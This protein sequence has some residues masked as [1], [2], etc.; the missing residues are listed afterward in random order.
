M[1]QEIFWGNEKSTEG[2]GIALDLSGNMYQIGTM[3]N[4]PH[5]N[6]DI[7]LVKF[8]ST[9]MEQWNITLGTDNF[10]F[11]SDVA[12]D[13]QGNVY[14][15]GTWNFSAGSNLHH[16]GLSKIYPNG[17][18]AWTILAEEGTLGNAI[19]L[20]DSNT[21][22]MGGWSSTL[23]DIII[24]KYDITGEIIWERAWH[25]NDQDLI[26]SS[27]LEVDSK[28]NVYVGATTKSLGA[29]NYDALLIKYNNQGQ[30][31]WNRTWG[32]MADDILYSLTIDKDDDIIIGG[33]TESFQVNGRDSIF[34][35]SFNETGELNKE[36]TWSSEQGA[37]LRNI[38]Q[39]AEEHLI[40]TGYVRYSIS[41]KSVLIGEV[42]NSLEIMRWNTTWGASNVISGNA[43][44][45]DFSGNL[46]ILGKFDFLG[47][48][49]NDAFILKYSPDVVTSEQYYLAI[50]QIIQDSLKYNINYY[51]QQEQE[52]GQGYYPTIHPP[53]LHATY[54]ALYILQS[55]G[56]LDEIN[57]QEI[58][59]YIMVHYNVSSG[60]FSD[61]YSDRYLDTD[62]AK[63]DPPPLTSY[64]EINCH[65]TLSLGIF[66][67]LDQINVQNIIDFI[68]SCYHPLKHGFL[69]QPYDDTLTGE[70][71]LPT[72]DNT[73]F[74]IKTLLLLGEDWSTHAQEK[75]ELISWLASLQE[76]VA[77]IHLGGFYNDL[78]SSFN[79]LVIKETNL[80][81]S[82]YCVKS[83]ELLNSLDQINMVNFNSYLDYLYNAQED[84]FVIAPHSQ[85]F[86]MDYCNLVATA[87]GLDLGSLAN[88][89]N[90][91]S[92]EITNYLLSHRNSMG[93]WD[94]STE[95]PYHEI[96][97]T[98][99]IIRSINETGFMNSLTED[100]KDEIAQGLESF[101]F[102]GGYSLM[103]P[104]YTTLEKLNSLINAFYYYDYNLLT[105]LDAPYL[106]SQFK[107]SF[108]D[109]SQFDVYQF[110][111]FT[112]IDGG[113]LYYHS[114]PFEFDTRG[115]HER[116]HELN[117]PVNARSM[118]HAL[119]TLYKLDLFDEFE[120]ETGISINDI[121]GYIES[122]QF[123]EPGYSNTGGFS[124]DGFHV[125]LSNELRNSYVYLEHSYYSVLTLDLLARYLNLGNISD[126]NIN[127]TAL[128]NYVLSHAVET[129][130]ELYFQPTYRTEAEDSLEILET[131]YQSLAIL[132]LV[133]E[134]L[135]DPQKIKNYAESCLIYSNLEELYLVYKINELLDLGMFF[136]STLVRNLILNTYSTS[137]H[138][139]Y[140]TRDKFYV[141]QASLSWVAD[142]SVSLG[143]IINDT[144]IPLVS[145]ENPLNQSYHA[146]QTPSLVFHVNETYLDAVYLMLSNGTHERERW[147]SLNEMKRIEG[148]WTFN[149]S[150]FEDDWNFFGNGTLTLTIKATDIQKNNGTDVITLYK[151]LSHP[152]IIIHSPIEGSLHGIQAPRYEIELNGKILESFWYVINNSHLTLQSPYY[153]VNDYV[154]GQI[155][156]AH[157]N[158]FGNESIDLTFIV[159]NKAGT[160]S[161]ATI[162]LQKD[163]ILPIITILQPSKDNL[164][165]GE[166]APSYKIEVEDWNV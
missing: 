50:E 61:S 58:M 111:L 89:P 96:I 136:N 108:K 138:S 149:D 156:Q 18:I 154:Q 151:E 103:S 129:T 65:A 72:A 80:L 82:Y 2:N 112:N 90:I 164:I 27:A 83:L 75:N 155:S 56:K 150:I 40:L 17:T 91:N 64:L 134:S 131:T 81:A 7:Y 99:Q 127:T 12:C 147:I 162:R 130:D 19:A 92:T 33:D 16:A 163:N 76:T 152:S 143:L 46:F 160:C 37:Y 126:T 135:I 22:Y 87:L 86:N 95:I 101:K 119:D 47:I 113:E 125:Y 118:Y 117:A 104:D 161:N 57:T 98:Y 43:I 140:R 25:G 120:L 28:G 74:A 60:L 145:I 157:W 137:L 110:S 45:K 8:D 124:P 35:V 158:R 153:S 105:Q 26:F 5:G 30:E 54:Y 141:P 115:T 71:A 100:V 44:I 67:E 78:D 107:Q 66:N 70:L 68:W 41:E 97:Y 146:W 20:E 73:Y 88:N 122:C 142:M 48:H 93:I 11:G 34:M 31:Q 62:L 6:D 94:K 133:N 77:G 49:E 159:K 23:N 166:Q 106:L 4:G 32:G 29:G 1:E 55:I 84:Y 42:D 21:I 79:S 144:Q 102:H 10:D 109:Y 36:F 52:Q 132:K 123:M 128:T 24:N 139:F 9:G 63:D 59:E 85:Y 51:D 14:I 121:L 39:S 69:G 3:K 53:S 13:S 38:F 165:F 116:V 114:H 148:I 15:V